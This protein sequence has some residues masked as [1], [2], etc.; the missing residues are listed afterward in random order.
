MRF[1]GSKANLL[2]NIKQ[3]IDENCKDKNETFCDIFS[4]TGIVSRF[5]KPYYQ[6]ISNDILH[7]SY[8]LTAATIENNAVPKF[9]LLSEIGI[10]DP[11]DYLESAEIPL[12]QDGFVTESYSPKGK[13]GRMYLTEEN[14]ERIDFIRASIDDWRN[15]KLID[16]YEFKYLLACLIEGVP[17]VSNTTG[18]YG[19]YLKKWDKRAFKRFEMFRLGVVDNNRRNI[20]YNEDANELIKKIS[21]DIIY[22]DPPYNNR[23]Y[24]SNYHVLETISKNDSPVLKGITGVRPYQNERSDYCIKRKVYEAFNEL[25]E[26]ADFKHIVISYS[27]DGLLSVEDLT[28]ILGKHCLKKSIKKYT[29]PYARYQSKLKQKKKEHNEYIFY[30]EKIGVGKQKPKVNTSN[31]VKRRLVDG[32]RFVQSPMNY[33]GGKYRQLPQLMPLFPQNINNFIDLFA[34]GFSVTANVEAKKYICN[35]LNDRVVEMVRTFSYADVDVIL[36]R[37]YEKIEEYGLSKENEEGFKS[38]RNF[39]NVNQNPIDLFTLS[40]YSFN[41]QFRFNNNMEYNNPFGRNRSQFSETTKQKL[42]LFIE[43]MKGKDIEFF[44]RDFREIDISGFNS[45]DFIY[46]D[47]PYLISNG[48][49]ND[50]NRGFKDWKKEEESAL[51]VYLDQANSL[52]IKFALSNMVKHKSIENYILKKWASKYNVHIIDSNYSN[53]NYQVK[54]KNAETVEVLVT[55]Y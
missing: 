10:N 52:G 42:I 45:G 24:L 19:A 17:F 47:P 21:G 4:G 36:K 49:Y 46:C 54:N 39:Y 48:S 26:N 32:K 12:S 11:I 2:E 38:F 27:E 13:A 34:G 6:I 8:V 50:G 29:I 5:F 7:F 3:V 18:T 35:D 31:R 16:Q 28:E 22:I 14:A 51:Y 55:N 44:S 30:A 33:I 37:V 9:E 40:C 15:R 1:I 53:C 20:C 43:A 25:I 23:Q 41:Y